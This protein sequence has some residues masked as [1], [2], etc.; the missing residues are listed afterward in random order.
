MDRGGW[1]LQSMQSVAESDTTE[2]LRLSL[3]SSFML[4]FFVEGGSNNLHFIFAVVVQSLSSVPFFITLWTAAHQIPLFKSIES[5]MLSNHLIL[6]SS[7]LLLLSIFPS[8]RVF[9][10]ESCQVA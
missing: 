5:V 2:P 4:P 6:C 7:L 9:S 3:S 10:N 8:I 1:W